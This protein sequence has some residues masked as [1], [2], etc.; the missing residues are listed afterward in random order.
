MS[1]G[2]SAKIVN[3]SSS[4]LVVLV[5]FLLQIWVCP[6]SKVGAVRMLSENGLPKHKFNSITAKEV[7]KEDIFRKSLIGKDHSFNSTDKGLEDSKRRVPSCPD[8]LH[9]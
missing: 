6:D 4:L 5:F 2:S 8:P 1:F 9:N 7:K 3:S